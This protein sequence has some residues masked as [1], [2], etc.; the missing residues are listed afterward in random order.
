MIFS[1]GWNYENFII[2]CMTIWHIHII[3]FCEYFLPF[4][5]TTC[6]RPPPGWRRRSCRQSQ[7]SPGCCC[8]KGNPPPP[9][10]HQLTLPRVSVCA[11]YWYLGTKWIIRWDKNKL[12]LYLWTRLVAAWLYWHQYL[13]VEKQA[14]RFLYSGIS[15]EIVPWW[16]SPH[17]TH[18]SPC[19]GENN[20]CCQQYGEVCCRCSYH[21]VWILQM[22]TLLPPTWK[23]HGWLLWPWR[24]QKSILRWSQCK[25]YRTEGLVHSGPHSNSI[26]QALTSEYSQLD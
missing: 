23:M 18:P 10:W 17:H 25:V 26:C 16:Y 1:H 14:F 22:L 11:W 9:P 13:A 15:V 4:D 20:L 5:C 12:I 7:R 3:F 21:L 19:K 8:W 6:R 24:T 2:G